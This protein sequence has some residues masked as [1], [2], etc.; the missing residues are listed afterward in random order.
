MVNVSFNVM[1]NVMA[2]I[3]IKFIP[4]LS[5]EYIELCKLIRQHHKLSI[6]QNFN[7]IHVKIIKQYVCT[8]SMSFKV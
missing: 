4:P 3:F 8:K 1:V 2:S 6:S 5:N 7:R